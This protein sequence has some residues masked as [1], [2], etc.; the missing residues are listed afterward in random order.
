[1]A[2]GSIPAGNQPESLPA[3][4]LVSVAMVTYNHEKYIDQA[5]QGVLNQQTEFPFELVIGEDCSL[6][7]TRRIV[8]DYQQ[9]FPH[10]VRAIISSTNVGGP[11]NVL[12]VQQACQGKYIAFCEGDDYWHNPQKLQVQVGFLEANPDYG[13]AHGEVRIRDVVTGAIEPG[14]S[15]RSELWRDDNAYLEILSGS[16][17]VWTPTVC[18]RTTLYRTVLAQNPEFWDKQ[19]LMSDLQT[20]LEMSRLAKVKGITEQLATRNELPESTT[21]SRDPRKM[22]RFALSAKAAHEYY[23]K[24]YECPPDLAARIR[25]THAQCALYYSFKALDRE[26]AGRQYA[27]L[28]AFSLGGATRH[29]L[30]CMGSRSAWLQAAVRLI[31]KVADQSGR[32]LHRTRLID[33]AGATA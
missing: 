2:S 28:Q 26:E 24:K 27:A 20:W 9:R 13:L 23:L 12:R 11:Q 1:M 31:L 32:F 25:F 18:L 4:P 7:D 15:G 5:I 16:R 22:L 8:L 33:G 6:D 10:R 21:R 3:H 17:I 30:F 14:T 19:F 29:W